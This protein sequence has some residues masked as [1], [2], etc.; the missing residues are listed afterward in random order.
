[1]NKISICF[2]FALVFAVAG[3]QADTVI[4]KWSDN[5]GKVI[6]SQTP[7]P[8]GTPFEVVKQEAPV[9]LGN[10]AN[11]SNQQLSSVRPSR[12]EQRAEQE[13]IAQSEQIRQ[14]NCA[15]AQTNLSSL[16]SRGQVTIK[17][18]ELYRKL[19]EE[20]RQQRITEAQSQIDEFC[21]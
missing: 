2:F 13:R 18:G 20:E 4:Y 21:S 10:A 6:Y 3:V 8:S 12:S 19:T 15:Q 16:T 7:P 5:S 14:E 17:E 1:M 11:N 9:P